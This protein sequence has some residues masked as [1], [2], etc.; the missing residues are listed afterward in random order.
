M[1]TTMGKK[2][3]LALTSAFLTTII[4]LAV[5]ISM[6]ALAESPVLVGITQ[7]STGVNADAGRAIRDSV[8]MAIEEQNK[9]GG[10]R[11]RKIEYISRD[12]ACDPSKATTIA[13]EFVR[14]KI[15]AVFG[16][17]LSTVGIP[18]TKVFVPDQIPFMGGSAS[19]KL[20]DPKGPDGKSYYFSFCGSD[21]VIAEAGL[22]FFAEQGYKKIAIL[23][24]N[25]AWPTDIMKYQADLVK[26]KY[27]P[28]YGM[29]V[30][31]VVEADV[32]A[33]D[34][35]K[36]V[37]KIKQLNP[38]AVIANIYGTTFVPW[39]RA[40]RDL[41]YHPPTTG[42]WAL[43]ET[44]YLSTDPTLLYN[45]VGYSIYSPEKPQAAAKLK[46]FKERWG[47][48]PVAH[49]CFAYQEALTLFG[50]MKA[51]GF[52]GPAIRDYIA[53]KL[54]DTP[55]I[56]GSKTARCFFQ[57]GTP[58]FYSVIG[59]EDWAFVRINEKGEQVWVRP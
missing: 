22:S 24:L 23:Y 8:I 40:C 30:V 50:A 32:K 34:L 6:P 29:E 13:K 52:D 35:S 58:Y 31:G 36:E 20:W 3:T 43:A 54:T 37:A 7:G 15:A 41:D 45:F 27:G 25:V 57:E 55:V 26:K 16:A 18:E 14:K 33:T 4:A 51:V 10:I 5:L 53:T 28:K 19:R 17:T 59:P 12:N 38:D 39:F 21:P 47:Y 44:A 9:S 56:V 11:G 49:W 1:T 48:Q 42:Y 46:E 2:A